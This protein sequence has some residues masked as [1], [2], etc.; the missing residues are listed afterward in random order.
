MPTGFELTILSTYDS[1]FDS[2]IDLTSDFI[3]TPGLF[4]SVEMRQYPL[5]NQ[6][7]IEPFPWNLCE[8]KEEHD[9]AKDVK[10]RSE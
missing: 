3:S 2:G 6:R 8:I 4:T 7:Q 5:K 9:F 1:A 10:I